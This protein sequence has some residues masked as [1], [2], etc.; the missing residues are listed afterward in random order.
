MFYGT[1]VL[2]PDET[3]TALRTIARFPLY[4]AVLYRDP[5]SNPIYKLHVTFKISHYTMYATMSE[6]SSHRLNETSFIEA[7]PHIALKT[8]DLNKY[9]TSVSTNKAIM[10]GHYHVDLAF[11]FTDFAELS[12]ILERAAHDVYDREFN[13]LVEAALGGKDGST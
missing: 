5:L 12:T 2:I 10:D 13:Q 6:F 3:L 11:G 1:N 7:A 4:A 8:R 9:I